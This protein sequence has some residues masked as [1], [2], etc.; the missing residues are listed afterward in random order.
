MKLG[1]FRVRNKPGCG[2][3]ILEILNREY[4]RH[5]VRWEVSFC[6]FKSVTLCLWFEEWEWGELNVAL[7]LHK[8]QLEFGDGSGSVPKEISR[9]Q[10]QI[11]KF[12]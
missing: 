12:L 3:V 2:K 4:S 5:T 6:I 7:E 8:W 10:G 9:D 11:K 1:G